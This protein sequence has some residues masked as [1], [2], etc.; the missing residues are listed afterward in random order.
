MSGIGLIFLTGRVET[1]RLDHQTEVLRVA[2]DLESLLVLYP[3]FFDQ[4]QEGLV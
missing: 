2:G 3:V 1:E 4:L